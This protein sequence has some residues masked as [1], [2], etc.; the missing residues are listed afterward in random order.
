MAIICYFLTV[1]RTIESEGRD[2]PSLALPGYQLQLLKD[3][4]SVGK[5]V[6]L[7][8]YNAGPVDISWA[9]ENVDVILE[10]FL[11]G[12]AAGKGL[13]AILSGK[14]NPAGRLPYTWP[15]NMDQVS[16]PKKLLLTLSVCLFFVV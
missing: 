8:L 15:V 12:Q 11:P 5:P 2:R 10:N 1:G 4:Q 14:V 6:I 9:K 3:A 7:L 16:P 13:V